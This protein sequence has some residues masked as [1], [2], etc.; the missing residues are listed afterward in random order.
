MLIRTLAAA[1]ALALS[2]ISLPANALGSTVDVNIVDRISGQRASL[3]PAH[4]TEAS[5]DVTQFSLQRPCQASR[6]ILAA[7]KED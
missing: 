3:G 7:R 1:T 5:R 4:F 6:R 2:T